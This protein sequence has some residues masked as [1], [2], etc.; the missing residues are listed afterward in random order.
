M[1]GIFAPAKTPAAIVTRLNREIVRVVT[2]PDVKERIFKSGAEAV[3]SSPE[4]FGA[5][6]QSEVSRVSK[7]IKEAGIKAD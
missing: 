1:T 3:G 6:V 2:S 7:L 4:E 5:K